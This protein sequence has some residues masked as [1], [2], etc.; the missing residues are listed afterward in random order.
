MDNL[1]C[2]PISLRPAGWP[3][4]PAPAAARGVAFDATAAMTPLKPTA[5]KPPPGRLPKGTPKAEGDSYSTPVSK[6]RNWTPPKKTGTFSNMLAQG[7]RKLPLPINQIQHD[8]DEV[9]EQEPQDYLTP[10]K[11]TPA[12]RGFVA[13]VSDR[14]IDAHNRYDQSKHSPPKIS[15]PSARLEPSFA[16]R[17]AMVKEG[18]EHLPNS[19]SY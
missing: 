4:A 10:K 6:G 2:G 19:V 15:N 13:I 5:G 18:L 3:L 11:S 17:K 14:W 7:L 16:K 12:R 8:L 9:L 1:R